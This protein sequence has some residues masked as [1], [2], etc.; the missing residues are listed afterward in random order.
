MRAILL[1]EYDP[2]KTADKQS[3]VFYN[4]YVQYVQDELIKEARRPGSIIW[5]EAKKAS[6][7]FGNMFR[8]TMLGGKV[9]IIGK[10]GD[11][12]LETPQDAM[13][14]LANFIHSWNMDG[15]LSKQTLRKMKAMKAKERETW[16]K[17]IQKSSNVQSLLDRFDINEDN[18]TSS[19][20]DRM[21]NE[22][23]SKKKGGSNSPKYGRSLALSHYDALKKSMNF[24]KKDKEI[25]TEVS[26]LEKE[27]ED[28][29]SSLTNRSSNE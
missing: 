24:G 22:V 4:E 3:D 13:N 5:K 2:N 29:V 15:D 20:L 9:P 26:E 19:K 17:T 1:K 21:I 23:L 27:Y 25:I 6:P 11:F 7:S 14:Y 10:G 8:G 28:E 12:T 16:A 18:Y